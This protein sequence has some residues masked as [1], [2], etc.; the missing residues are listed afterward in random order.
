MRFR[1]RFYLWFPLLIVGMLIQ[2]CV[3][4]GMAQITATPTLKEPT[5]IPAATNT[6]TPV[7]SPSPTQTSMPDVIPSSMPS[8]TDIPKRV[9]EFVLEMLETNGDCDLPCIWG[10]TPG[11]TRWT[12][13]EARLTAVGLVLDGEMLDLSPWKDITG[14]TVAVRFLNEKDVVTEIQVD[15]ELDAEIVFVGS[16]VDVCGAYALPSVLNRFGI[17]SEI[18]LSM[19]RLD[20]LYDL[21]MIYGYPGIAISYPGIMVTD[22]EGWTICPVHERQEQI[23]IHFHAPD[24]EPSN[25]GLD[26]RD[27]VFFAEGSLERLTGTSAEEFHTIYSDPQSRSC[28]F[29][30]EAFQRTYDEILVAAEGNR[31]WPQAETDILVSMLNSDQDCDDPCWWGIKPGKTSWEVA[32]EH[33]LSLGKSIAIY[34]DNTLNLGGVRRVALFGRHDPYPFEYM[35]EHEI[36][37]HGGIVSLIG[38]RAQTFGGQPMG[39]L[40]QDWTRYTAYHI[41]ARYGI[42]SEIMLHYWSDDPG[43]PYTVGLIYERDGFMVEYE[44]RVRLLPE[45]NLEYS[46]QDGKA[47]IC[48]D[49][50]HISGI[51][52]WIRSPWG[53]TAMSEVFK[54]LGGR[55]PKHFYSTPTLDEATGMSLE[56]FYEKF[57][58]PRPEICLVADR[59]L[60]DLAE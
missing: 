6:I 13:L 50:D 3:L 18:N 10:I 32:R 28:L 58:E 20:S 31:M 9:T 21:W 36:Y 24:A 40:L 27:G 30:S 56:I 44:G 5:F 60:G 39:E 14:H 23:N 2:G 41:L 45:D 22:V 48:L 19:D 26:L 47:V 59:R 57:F 34:S 29:A 16:M 33:F 8:P 43:S 42:P 11:E 17:P 49:E 38:A 12:E 53:S 35:L 37:E 25:P 7:P 15:C 55:F 54:Q 4:P 52:V 1:A 46:A 51:N